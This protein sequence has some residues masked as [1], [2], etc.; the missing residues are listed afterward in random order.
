[1][2]C[3]R[4]SNLSDSHPHL[5]DSESVCLCYTLLP[6]NGND[7]K[8][9]GSWAFLELEATWKSFVL[10]TLLCRSEAEVPPNPMT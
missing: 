10:L 4:S 9:V 8:Q 1:M 7:L 2:E 3:Q 5:S 6:K